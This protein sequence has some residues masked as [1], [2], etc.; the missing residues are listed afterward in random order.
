MSKQF[1]VGDKVQCVRGA[2]GLA[3]GNKYTV[4][5]ASN[6]QLLGNVVSVDG[7]RPSGCAGFYAT[8]FELVAVAAFKKGDKVRYIGGSGWAFLNGK[9]G[10]VFTV[11][12]IVPAEYSTGTFVR[13]VEGL[14]HNPKHTQ[15]LKC[16]ELVKPGEVYVSVREDLKEAREA[17]LAISYGM[18]RANVDKLLFGTTVTGR[19]KC[20]RPTFDNLPKGKVR[21]I[22]SGK[23]LTTEFDDEQ[24]AKDWLKDNECVGSF[25]L[26]RV[27]PLGKVKVKTAIVVEAV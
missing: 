10:Q 27:I 23:L 2:T 21:L 19:F 1:K 22:E 13:I 18:S 7:L 26:V 15:P 12:E 16:F 14:P 25:E 11:H 8:R 6:D 5:S 17:I 3:L 24:A 4:T 9:K 20:E